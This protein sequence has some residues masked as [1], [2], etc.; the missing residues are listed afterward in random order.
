[1][2]SSNHSS[3]N[4]SSLNSLPCSITA[5]IAFFTSSG[6]IYTALAPQ[7]GDDPLWLSYRDM[8]QASYDIVM[9]LMILGRLE[10]IV[11]FAPAET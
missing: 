11:F 8:P 3:A 9:I 4:F 7:L 2:F 5:S 10:I 6:P 1:M